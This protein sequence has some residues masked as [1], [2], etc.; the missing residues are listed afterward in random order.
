M[1]KDVEHAILEIIETF[2]ERSEE[3]AKQ[4]LENLKETGRYL[5]DVY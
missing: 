2:G 3:E 1:S 4:Y 5:T